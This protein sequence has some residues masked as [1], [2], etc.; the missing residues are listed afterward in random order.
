MK[1]M[2]RT[3]IK[4]AY[5]KALR[6]KELAMIKLGFA[7]VAENDH[8]IEKHNLDGRYQKWAN[9]VTRLETEYPWLKA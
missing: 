3:E 8:S 6:S 2:S 5:A 7:K 4:S 1:K 9:E